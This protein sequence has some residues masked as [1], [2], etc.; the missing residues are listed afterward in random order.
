MSTQELLSCVSENTI[1]M[2]KTQR[3]AC[4]KELTSK[5]KGAWVQSRPKQHAH[6][7]TEELGVN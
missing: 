5:K 6:I 2:S 7:N 3:T 1:R 4:F